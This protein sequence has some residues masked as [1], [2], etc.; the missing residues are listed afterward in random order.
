MFQDFNR[1]LT[2]SQDIAEKAARAARLKTQDSLKEDDRKLRQLEDLAGDTA[3]DTFK[4][5]DINARTE[6]LTSKLVDYMI[7]EME[8]RLDRIY[9]EALHD[10]SGGPSGQEGDVEEEATIKDELDS[11]YSEI[12]VLA[13]MAV[14]Q[15]FKAPILNAV[16]GKETR[17]KDS[18]EARLGYVRFTNLTSYLLL[19]ML[20]ISIFR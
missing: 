4:G 20:D 2:E 9:M 1:K 14:Q 19:T 5:R 7:E 10:V 6:K 16:R 13:E 12:G 3:M 15:E 18:S 8:S 17:L 11:L